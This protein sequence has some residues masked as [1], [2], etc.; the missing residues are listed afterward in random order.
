M[1][2]HNQPTPAHTFVIHEGRRFPVL[3]EKNRGWRLRSKS[4]HHPIDVLLGLGTEAW[5]K[6]RA[7]EILRGDFVHTPK[8]HKNAPTVGD[9]VKAYHAMPKR[10]GAAAAK[11]AA[12][13]LASVIRLVFGREPEAVKVDELTPKM[14]MIYSAKRQEREIVDLATRRLGNAAINA[15]MKQASSVLA[16]KLRPSF[17]EAGIHIRPDATVIQWLPETARENLP[18][19]DAAMIEAWAE[20][21]ES[22]LALWLCIGL[23]RFAGLR[24]S[25]I[26]HCQ[27]H[28]LEDVSGLLKVRLK[29]R[30]AEG[31]LNKTGRSYAPKV[32][33]ARLAEVLRSLPPGYV[34]NP[35]DPDR[36]RWFERVPQAWLRPFVGGVQKPLH[37]LRG[38]YADHV[39]QIEE[40]AITARL[41]GVKA[42]AAALGHTSTKTTTDHYLS[43]G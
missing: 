29:D 26:E 35:P 19:D 40:E 20:L 3:V 31:W 27:A 6:K 25:E 28:W 8:A 39:A 42:A 22:D 5:A 24:R 32:I 4:K 36:F 15:A 18:A 34:V 41:A 43:E 37:R 7:L 30:P 16:A 23:A 21:E 11:I 13:R 33:H 14:W 2:A 17:A 10:A 9:L 12:Y 1:S 38:L